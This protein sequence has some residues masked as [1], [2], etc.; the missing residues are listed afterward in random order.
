MTYG[1]DYYKQYLDIHISGQQEAKEKLATLAFAYYQ[2]CSKIAQGTP[3][4]QLPNLNMFL[5]G[6]TG[7]GKTLCC[8]TIAK[9]LAVPFIRID[10]GSLSQ[11][12]WAGTSITDALKPFSRTLGPLGF[13]VILLDEFDKLGEQVLSTGGGCPNKSI[14]S[15]LLDLLDGMLSYSLFGTPLNNC[16]VICGGAFTDATRTHKKNSKGIGFSSVVDTR[17]VGIEDY[18]ELMVKAGILQEIVGRMIDVVTL[19]H[20][21]KDEVRDTLRKTNNIY[22]QYT[23]LFPSFQLTEK[24]LDNVVDS[25]YDKTKTFGVRE[26]QT[27]IFQEFYKRNKPKGK[28]NETS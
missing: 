23:K 3:R 10:C 2:R 4:Q 19:T 15:N 13:G 14:Q 12:G 20:L 9:A 22:E 8:T 24:E 6:P 7:C 26:L 27:A 21:T 18:K 25:V 16:L 28:E 1:V 5:V 17:L 11:D